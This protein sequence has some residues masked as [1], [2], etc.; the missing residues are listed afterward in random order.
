VKQ[1]GASAL[2]AFMP[3]NNPNPMPYTMIGSSPIRFGSA[4]FGP[5][6][7]PTGGIGELHAASGLLGECSRPAIGSLAMDRPPEPAGIEPPVSC[8]AMLEEEVVSA[9]DISKRA[10]T[11]FR[12][13][14]RTRGTTIFRQMLR[15]LEHIGNC[16]QTGEFSNA[17]LRCDVSRK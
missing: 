12:Y 4:A 14:T 10:G 7:G 1:R 11:G 3:G 17:G 8:V 2:R 9:Q 5:T 15:T 6:I 13:R 16:L